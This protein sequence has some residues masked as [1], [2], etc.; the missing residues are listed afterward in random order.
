MPFKWHLNGPG[1]IF[2]QFWDHLSRTGSMVGPF[3]D[4]FWAIFEH[5]SKNKKKEH[6]WT[7]LI[8]IND[9]YSVASPRLYNS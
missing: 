8:K 5:P 2:G 1:T 4:H 7:I 6:F 9:S 3:L